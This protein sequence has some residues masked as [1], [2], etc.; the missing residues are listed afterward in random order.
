MSY[1]GQKAPPGW[2]DR[3]TA[4]VPLVVGF[5]DAGIDKCRYAAPPFDVRSRSA[6]T[7]A[8]AFDFFPITVLP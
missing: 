3:F 5:P 6:D 1:A 2:T 8:V 7:A 4:H